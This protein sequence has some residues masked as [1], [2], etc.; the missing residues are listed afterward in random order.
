[1]S[2]EHG[3]VYLDPH[4][5]AALRRKAIDACTLCDEDGYSVVGGMGLVCDH[6]DRR[7]TVRRGMALVREALKGKPNNPDVLHRRTHLDEIRDRQLSENPT[8][9]PEPEL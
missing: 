4:E 8:V 6:V 9:D 2:D 3:E 5:A 7:E 1:M